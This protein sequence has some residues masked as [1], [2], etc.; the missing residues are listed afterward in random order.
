MTGLFSDH[1]KSTMGFFFWQGVAILLNHYRHQKR[2]ELKRINGHQEHAR[3]VKY[4]FVRSG[5][6][7]K[8]KYFFSQT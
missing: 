1:Y 7:H 6:P 5:I 8:W 3:D 2:S 4:I